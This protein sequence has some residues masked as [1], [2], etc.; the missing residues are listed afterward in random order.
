MDPIIV[1]SL[2][3]LAQSAFPVSYSPASHLV[4]LMLRGEYPECIFLIKRTEPAS[5]SPLFQRIS[6]I[7]DAVSAGNITPNY[8]GDTAID[9]RLSELFG[10][11]DAE[12]RDLHA[13][14]YS[15]P[16]ANDCN[17]QFDYM[18]ITSK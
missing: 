13:R 11:L 16:A 1:E 2:A 17:V 12:R 14:C 5:R 15:I 3:E 4:T 10:K 9:A 7:F 18:N 6:E 8:S